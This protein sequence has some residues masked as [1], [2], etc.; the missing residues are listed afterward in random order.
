MPEM[1]PREAR[2]LE[3]GQVQQLTELPQVLQ[4]HGHAGERPGLCNAAVCVRAHV[5]TR[6][7]VYEH[8]YM[9]LDQ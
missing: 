3:R 9:K 4:P 1:H 2:A 7:S 8:T 5:F 6:V